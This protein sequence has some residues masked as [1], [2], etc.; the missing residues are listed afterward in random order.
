MQLSSGRDN[1]LIEPKSSVCVSVCEC[2][3]VCVTAVCRRQATNRWKQM[4]RTNKKDD[5]TGHN[6]LTNRFLLFS[7]LPFSLLEIQIKTSLL[8][9]SGSA[10]TSSLHIQSV[11]SLTGD[12]INSVISF[13]ALALLAPQQRRN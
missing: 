12:L 6:I 7:F 10:G 8:S 2:V 9:L 3:C 11:A 4:E 1:M 5:P 13:L